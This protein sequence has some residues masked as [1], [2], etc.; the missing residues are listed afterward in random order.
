MNFLMCS[1]LQTVTLGV[2]LIGA[3]NR[4]DRT[5]AHQVLFETGISGG[6]GGIAFLSPIMAFKR[7]KPVSGSF[8]S[9]KFFSIV[10]LQLFMAARM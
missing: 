10:T 3:G 4:R 7:K 6:I 5:P 2:N 8:D 1:T 9:N